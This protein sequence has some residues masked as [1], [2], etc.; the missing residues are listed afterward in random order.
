MNKLVIGSDLR[1]PVEAVTQ[2]FA[3]LAKRGAG[4]TY[5]GAVMAEEMLKASADGKPPGGLRRE[6]DGQAN[7]GA[8]CAVCMGDT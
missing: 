1:L 5:L 6:P 8:V 3:F 7:Q 4:K 2:T